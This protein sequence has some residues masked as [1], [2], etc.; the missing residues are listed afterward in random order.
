MEKLEQTPLNLLL[1][2]ICKS[3]GGVFQ[4]TLILLHPANVPPSERS[5]G[6]IPLDDLSTDSVRQKVLELRARFAKPRLWTCPVCGLTH[7]RQ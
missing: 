5:T 6:A 2:H 4:G 7:V 1:S 3:G